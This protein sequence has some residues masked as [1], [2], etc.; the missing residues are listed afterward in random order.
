MILLLR[1]IPAAIYNL[2]D[3]AE[4]PWLV[5][6]I[7]IAVPPE[8]DSSWLSR[9]TYFMMQKKPSQCLMLVS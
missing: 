2:A 3:A 4:G 7:Q 1:I 9:F 6:Q 8:K 5:S